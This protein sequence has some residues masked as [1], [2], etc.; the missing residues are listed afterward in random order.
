MAWLQIKGFKRFLR[1][2]LLMG[3]FFAGVMALLDY[4]QG[5]PYNPKRFV[6]QFLFF[7]ILNAAFQVYGLDRK[8][9]VKNKE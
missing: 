5:L 8:K 3:L 6:F 2:A 1:L 4:L 7:G 9:G